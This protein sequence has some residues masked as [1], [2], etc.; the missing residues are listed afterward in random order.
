MTGDQTVGAWRGRVEDDALLRGR[1]RFADDGRDA[2]ET[3]ACFV[4][5]PHASARIRAV[6]TGAAMRAHGVLAVLTAVDMAGVGSISGPVPQKGLR[7]IA[8]KVPDRPALAG[9]PVALVVAERA[10]AAQ[11]AAELVEVSYDELPPAIDLRA[12]AADGAPQV[13]PE[14]PGN[15]AID[16]ALGDDPETLR[17]VDEAFRHARHVARVSLVNQRVVVASMEPRGATAAYDGA[18][19]SYKLRCG[20]QGVTMLRDQL[21]GVLGVERERLR[22][23]TDDVGGAFGMKAP[24]YPEYAALLIAAKK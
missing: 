5:S 20:S 1:G 13:H 21:L 4:R 16:F 17:A 10:A 2:N 19:D 7:G 14:A 15:V 8:L 23:V 9:E 11:D 6:D 12:A 22:V 24:A 18:S 3:Y